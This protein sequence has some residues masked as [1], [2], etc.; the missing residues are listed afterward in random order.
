MDFGW[1]ETLVDDWSKVRQ[2]MKRIGIT[3]TASYVGA[4]QTNVSGGQH[5][6]WSYVG[7]LS[8]AL[9]ADMD[10]LIRVPGLSAYVEASWGTGSNLAAPLDSVMPA[11]GQVLSVSSMV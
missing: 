4:L 7:L 3:P 1:D 2:E 6:V 10:E 9:S 8:F 5:E 11:S